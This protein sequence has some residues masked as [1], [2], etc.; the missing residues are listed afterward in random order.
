M[1]PLDAYTAFLALV[2]AVILGRALRR[3]WRE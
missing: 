3:L 2:A 1:T